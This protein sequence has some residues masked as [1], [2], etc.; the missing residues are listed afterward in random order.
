MT[1]IAEADLGLG[2]TQL[3]P[4]P[5]LG[6][7]LAM[8]DWASL[9]DRELVAALE[10]A[11][12]QTSWAQSQKLTAIAE[13]A[14]RRHGPDYLPDSDTER[15][16]A[17]EVSLALTTTHGQ[18]QELLWLAETLPGRLPATWAALQHGH[19]DYDR[20]KVMCDALGAL[21]PDLAR[22]LDAELIGDAVESTRTVLRRKLTQAIKAADPDAHA[23]RTTKAKAERRF[24]LWDNENDT[25]DLIGRNIDGTEAHAIYNRLTAAA[26]ALKTDGDPR[27]ID[28]LRA[29]L[30]TALLRGIPLPDAIRELL[31]NPTDPAACTPAGDS[32]T[33]S[34]AASPRAAGHARQDGSADLSGAIDAVDTL[35]ARALAEVADEHLTYLL[36]CAQAHRRLDSLTLLIGHATQ[37]ITNALTG[38]VESWC[39]A[40]GAAGPNPKTHGHHRYRPPAAMQRL[41]QRRHPTCVFPTCNR[42]SIHCDIDHTVPFD[43]GG[44]TCKCNLAPLCRT[45]HRIIKQH[46]SWKLLQPWP[47]FLIWLTPAGFW[48]IVTPQ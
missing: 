16:I 21:D 12:R 24:E 26:H 29:D 20:A 2:W 13:L 41:I 19:L 22:A 47:G 7:W 39:R 38:I 27:P 37:T 43:K 1:A 3:P 40:T 5:E 30:H 48:H 23:A 42:R 15:R 34:A 33:R 4:G 10:A 35:I 28:Q 25:C 6:I 45:H 11:D 44:R 18:A 46:P 32:T 36:D 14:R 9:P 31:A 17:G 8:V